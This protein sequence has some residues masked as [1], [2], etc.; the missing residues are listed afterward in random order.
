MYARYARAEAGVSQA[1][2]ILRSARELAVSQRRNVE[3]RFIGTDAIQTARVEVPDG[4]TT[5]VRTIQLENRMQFLLQSG[6]PDTPDLFGRSAAVAFGAS[7]TR[8]FTS[9]G[10][11]VDS[12]GDVLNG[13]LFMS[14][15]GDKNSAR[16]ITIF[17]TT[18]VLHAWRWNG[19][20]WTD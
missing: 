20:R 14:V 6:I 1:L 4:T 19:S 2:D 12:N 15:P 17:G 5:V 7:P 13:T 10:T 8:M 18:A 16:A 11:F 3:V 9:E